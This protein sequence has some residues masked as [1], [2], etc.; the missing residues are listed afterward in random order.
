MQA[1]TIQPPSRTDIRSTSVPF[2]VIITAKY[3]VQSTAIL[4]LIQMNGSGWWWY[5]V[6]VVMVVDRDIE[7]MSATRRPSAQARRGC[8]SSGRVRA[9]E[10]E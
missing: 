2:R 1:N 3:E 8:S 10:G 5:F 6:V 9:G 7:P 4:T